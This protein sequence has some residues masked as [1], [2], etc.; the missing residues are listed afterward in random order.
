MIYTYYVDFDLIDHIDQ[1]HTNDHPD[2]DQDCKTCL[3]SPESP[4]A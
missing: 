1:K 3:C 2:N 4:A